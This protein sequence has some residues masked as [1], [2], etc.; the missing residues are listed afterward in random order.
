MKIL[1]ISAIIACVAALPTIAS[2][3]DGEALFNKKCK[4]CHALE[5]GKNKGGP[6]LNVIM[7]KTAGTQEGYKK[8][9]GLAGSDIVWSAD[10]MDSFLTDPSG[11]L[12]KKSSM[13]VK[14]KDA[15]ERAAIIEFLGAQ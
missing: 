13:M 5:A 7:G 12:G 14:V 3:A 6:S 10:T 4:L 8:Y 11:F 9:A 15:G 1:K 2:A